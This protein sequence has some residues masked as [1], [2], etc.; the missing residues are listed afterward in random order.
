VQPDAPDVRRPGRAVAN[1]GGRSYHEDVSSPH[2]PSCQQESPASLAPLPP[3]KPLRIG[4]MALGRGVLMRGAAHWAVAREDGSMV[5]GLV[6]RLW[7]GRAWRDWPLVRSLRGLAEMLLLNLTLARLGRGRRSWRLPAALLAG[8]LASVALGSGLQRVVPSAL[9]AALLLQCLGVVIALAVLQ[10]GVGAEVWRYHGAEHKAVNAYEAGADLRDAGAVGRFS[11]VHPRC[12]TNV[13][14]VLL[15][16]SL[17]NVPLGG[18]VTAQLASAGVAVLT[19]VV[20]F[21]YF[22]AVQRWPR[23]PVH[24]ALIAAGGWLQRGVTTREPRRPQVQ[25][26]AAALLRVVELELGAGR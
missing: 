1:R 8:I 12:G 22:R 3:A 20:A 21:E 10:V 24:R 2:A 18:G 26:A 19:F 4:G 23:F 25:V 17:V 7:D 13:L 9:L 14:V 6:P 15:L 11:R 5:D 16:L